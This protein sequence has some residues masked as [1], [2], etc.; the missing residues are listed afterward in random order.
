LSSVIEALPIL[1]KQ[2]FFEKAVKLSIKILKN[3][4]VPCPVCGKLM[5]YNERKHKLECH[6]PKCSLIAIRVFKNGTVRVFNQPR[7]EKT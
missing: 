3:K 1:Q 5:V 2:L 6:N 7:R 4:D